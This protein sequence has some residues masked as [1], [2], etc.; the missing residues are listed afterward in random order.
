MTS[1]VGDRL[2]LMVESL[3]AVVISCIVTLVMAWRF[4]VVLIAIQP[5]RIYCYYTKKVL[6]KRLSRKSIKAQNQ[7][8]QVATECIANHRTI[9]A[10]CCEERILQLFEST[11]E[12]PHQEFKIQS[13]Y[14]GLVLGICEFVHTSQGSL[15][16]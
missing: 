12:A 7:T 3:S 5:V 6:L 4:A 13:W 9:A 16:F 2:S 15:G 10:F 11:Q 8:S 1:L 14:A